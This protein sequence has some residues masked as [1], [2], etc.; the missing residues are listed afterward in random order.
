ML[1]VYRQRMRPIT[2]VSAVRRLKHRRRP[3]STMRA[4]VDLADDE[5]VRRALDGR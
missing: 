3:G 2:L 5:A 4:R 1:I